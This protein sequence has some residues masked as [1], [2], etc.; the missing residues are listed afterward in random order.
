MRALEK[1]WIAF[2]RKLSLFRATLF[3]RLPNLHNLHRNSD[4]ADDAKNKALP[5]APEIYIFKFPFDCF[6]L[7]PL[8]FLGKWPICCQPEFRLKN[9]WAK[10]SKKRK[11]TKIWVN[12]TRSF[13][14]LAS[15]RSGILSGQQNGYL[16]HFGAWEI[17]NLF[18]LMRR[19]WRVNRRIQKNSIWSRMLC[20]QLG[21][22]SDIRALSA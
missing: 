1:I 3:C 18:L 8:P 2:D 5:N 20:N 11:E 7:H 13:K 9:G 14:F 21:S 12:L 19:F 17:R 16:T 4:A 6:K 10:R 22:A 15:L